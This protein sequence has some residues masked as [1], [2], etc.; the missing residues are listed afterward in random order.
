[1]PKIRVTGLVEIL[2]V[3][4]IH[5]KGW[6][7]A[8][9]LNGSNGS[10]SV[11]SGLS[12]ATGLK[13]KTRKLT[14]NRLSREHAFSFEFHQHATSPIRDQIPPIRSILMHPANL[15]PGCQL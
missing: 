9:G 13:K 2:F 11:Q 14:T 4:G 1:M 7:D 5:V 12:L 3:A 15:W 8:S 10:T 6:Q